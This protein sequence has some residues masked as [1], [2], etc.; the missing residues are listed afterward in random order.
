MFNLGKMF[1]N[2]EKIN[3]A[4][5]SISFDQIKTLE[6]IRIYGHYS[7]HHWG[8]NLPKNKEGFYLLNASNHPEIKLFEKKIIP[9]DQW[10][11]Y[12]INYY[13]FRDDW[14]FTNTLDPKIA[15][16]GDSFTFGDG[17]DAP[18]TH[19]KYIQNLINARTYN[20][21]K[22]GASLERIARIFAVFSKFVKYDIAVFTLP[23]IYREYFVDDAGFLTD[24]VPNTSEKSEHSKYMEQFIHLHE[25]YQKMK[26]SLCINY[27]LT[28]AEFYNIKVLINT[29]DMPTFDLLKIIAPDRMMK[30]VFPPTTDILNARDG[31]HPG[32]LA[33]HE[34]AD[35]IAKEL[36]DR[37]W[38]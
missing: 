3:D 1:S 11:K 21:G 14:N 28:V 18:D 36:Y 30:N 5:F 22:G 33:Q 37:A 38:I 8:R 31:L 27:I 29:W 35:E 32:P 17:I 19:P 15:F 10:W 6:G 23:H 25:N 2:D 4:L 20:V 24:L 26:L 7:P 13:N 12:K 9:E 16:F 34:Y